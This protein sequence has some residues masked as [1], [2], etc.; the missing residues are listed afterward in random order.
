MESVKP[1]LQLQHIDKHFG[2]VHALDDVS[3]DL[4]AGEILSLVGENGAGKST[5]M[6]IL[7]GQHSSGSYSGDIRINGDKVR[8]TKPFDAERSGV[9]M[10]YQEINVELD[11]SIAENVYL[12]ALPHNRY[13]FIDWKATVGG[14]EKILKRLG[15]KVNVKKPARSLSASYLQLVCIA[16]AL[17]KEPSILILDE[18][19]A[20]LTESEAQNLIKI[21]NELRDDGIS[22]I[23]IS[24]K[25]D[26]VLEIS[27]R[28]YVLRDGRNVAEYS[29]QTCC[30][31]DMVEDIVGR[32]LEALYPERNAKIGDVVFSI[33]GFTVPHPQVPSKTL[34]EDVAFSLRK[35]EILGLH[36]LVGSGRSELLR[37]IFGLLPRGKGRIFLNGEEIE[38]DSPKEAIRHGLGFL[39]EDRKQ[40]GF[41]HTMSVGH[42]ITLAILK[43]ISSLSFINNPA[44]KQKA[45][46]FFRKLRIKAPSFNTPITQLSGGNQQK[47]ILAKWLLT[48]LKVIFLDEPTRGI[49]VGAKAEIYKL[50]EILSER[51]ISIVMISS[52]LP[53]LMAMCDRFVVLG[54]G[55]VCGELA[56]AE[57][58]EAS[59]LH[60][61]A[62]G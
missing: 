16:R 53:E 9:A 39:T 37:S 47:A 41:V 36:G 55:H 15:V 35:G 60:A 29:G 56:R 59:L 18:P 42:N 48:E 32:K 62:F 57:A 54:R 46:D 10:I 5:L 30:S 13:G 26:E 24:H 19:T 8:F 21:L 2:V 45:L 4:F 61:A 27:D 51:G 38:I 7:S 43:E 20:A 44:E 50:M 1:I 14:A 17:V 49:D 34:I 31:E 3:I 25:L 33:E 40:D 12:G 28:I 58:T 52:E 22:C 6:K 23:Y 11:L